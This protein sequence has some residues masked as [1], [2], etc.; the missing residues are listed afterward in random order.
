MNKWV[1]IYFSGIFMGAADI[2]PGVSGGTI[3]FIL[4]VYERL[5]SAL[6]GVNKKSIQLLFKG[7]IKGLWKHFDASFLLVLGVGILTSLIALSGAISFALEFYPRY[8]ASFFLGLIL[9]S[10][11]LLSK[12][13]P[14]LQIKHLIM[15]LLGCCFGLLVSL[16]SP[17]NINVTPLMVILS[18]MIAICA[19]LLPGISG[20]FILLMLGMYGPVLL[21]I[22]NLELSVLALFASG[23]LLGLLTFSKLLKY[24]MTYFREITISFLIGVML[25]SLLKIWPWKNIGQWTNIDGKDVP[26]NVMYVMPWNINDYQM[27]SDLVYPLCFVLLGIFIIKAINNIFLLNDTNDIDTKR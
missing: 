15:I 22:K 12:D 11:A 18:G 9:A 3:A 25:G 8:L 4:G 7:D 20:S 6:S 10:A 1:K 13:L 17:T 21:A 27:S 2:V 26:E 24:L 5:I 23:A 16:L 14:K 19:M